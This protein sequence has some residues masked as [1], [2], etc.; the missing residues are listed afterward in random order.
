MKKPELIID[1]ST[2]GGDARAIM[3]EH[4]QRKLIAC[5]YRWQ[6][7]DKPAEPNHLDA[8]R[9]HV[10]CHGHH[11]LD[12]VPTFAAVL[13]IRVGPVHVFT[14]ETVNCFLAAAEEAATASA[15]IRGVAVTFRGE[16]TKMD[17]TT[18]LTDVAASAKA[19]KDKN[20]GPNRE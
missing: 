14:H 18:L 5:G 4:I 6:N 16:E 2:L 7:I 13:S 15:N 17:A 8:P 11:A 10:W 1:L 20:F 19:F 9:L 12:I 3:S